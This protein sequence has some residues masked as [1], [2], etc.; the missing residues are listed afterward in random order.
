[1]K[2]TT[3]IN[4]FALI[5]FIV[6]LILSI[7]FNVVQYSDNKTLKETNLSLSTSLSHFETKSD[8]EDVNEY[9]EMP[10][11]AAEKPISE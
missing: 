2:N 1:M 10:V 3:P 11:G 6:L 5:C 7:G 4:D 8:T 9:E